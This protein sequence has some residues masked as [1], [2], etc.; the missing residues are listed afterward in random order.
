MKNPRERLQKV[1]V[2]GATPAGIAA[3]NKLGEMG[4][5]VTLIDSAPDLNEKLASDTWR[6]PSGVTF[7]Y[8][9]RPGLLRIMRNPRIRLLLPASVGSIKHTPQGFSIR[10]TKAAVYV[11]ADKCTLC[12]LCEKNCPAIRPDGTRA[13]RY[14]GRYELPG[15]PVI[16]KRKTPLCQANCPLGVNV[17]GYIALAQAG[18]YAEAIELIRKDNFLPAICGRICTNPCEA[19]C[20]RNEVDQPVAIRDIKR[21]LADLDLGSHKRPLPEIKAR[22]EQKVAIIGSGP[23]GLSC[24]Y[25]LA[26][27]G[28]KVSVFEKLPV[29]GGMLSVGIPAYRL[30]KDVIN[31]E[32][33]VMRDMGVEFQTGVEAGRDFT[34]S[35]L[36]AQGFKAFFMGP[37]LQK[38][39][40]LGIPGEDLEGVV[41]GVEYLRDI[42]LGAQIPLGNRVAIIGGGSVA[43]DAAR[44]VLRNGSQRPVIIYRRSE[45]EMPAIREEV[46]ECREEGIE[47]M[48]LTNPSRIVGGNGR[49][50]GVECIKM[51]LGEPDAGGRRRP[52]PIAGSEFVMEV[53]AVI[54]AIGQETDWGP[55]TEEC[56]FQ[57]TDHGTI[58]VNQPTRNSDIFVGGDAVTGPSTVVSAMASGRSTAFAIHR[59][60]SGEISDRSSHSRP[61]LDFPRI[62]PETPCVPRVVKEHSPDSC[63]GLS[64][65]VDHGL[66]EDQVLSEASRCLQC[67]VCS[68]C[69]QCAEVCPAAGAISHI[70]DSTEGIEHAGVVIIADPEAAPGIKGEDVIRAY[71]AK[72]LNPEVFSMMSRGFSAAAEAILL[73][74]DSAPR[75]KGR[76]L[77]FSPPAPQLSSE[78]R[79]GVFVCRCNDSLG[80][81]PELERFIYDLPEIPGVE[82]AESIASACT[83]EGSASILRTIR[84]KGLT[85]FVLASCVC[86]PLDL[87][88]SACTD[89]RSRLKTALFQGTGITRAMAET[90]NLR[91][92]ALSLLGRDPALAVSRF[93]GL[94]QRSISRC[95][96]LKSFPTPARQYN[97]TTAVIGDSRAALRS[98]QTLGEMGME[99]FLFGSS[100]R[101]LPSTPDCPNVHAFYGSCAKSLRGTVGEFELV[102]S[103][104]DGGRQTFS[105]GA[106][107]LGDSARK[108]LAYM[109]H[110]DMPPHEFC[111]SM[112]T[113]GVSGI[114]FSVPGATSIPG[115]LLANPP[116]VNLSERIKGSAAAILAAS[117]MPRGPRQSKGYTVS[118]NDALCRG[119][120]RC[121]RACPYRAI[122]FHTNSS[123]FGYAVIDEALCKGC[124]N[125]ISICPSDAADSPYRD[126]F[127]LEQIIEEVVARGA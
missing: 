87:I 93:K 123:G 28:Y 104:E 3:T 92:E 67:G 105:V 20:R 42:N 74:G 30:P 49:V 29:L 97:F 24:A 71:S 31:A 100:E 102:V 117:V 39:K 121:V 5:Q 43:V 75:M 77:S 72:T 94:L 40:A 51:E 58:Q 62:R 36:R 110:P 46:I 60:L 26:I 80:W 69:R 61:E 70:D 81:D 76:G 112:Q 79:I 25:H 86:C 120:G 96:H 21:F 119:C 99:V 103:M 35:Q 73:L 52:I 98:A 101:P 118:I 50:Q 115:L 83:P 54:P 4:I 45:N 59:F 114:P 122:S 14:G 113:N 11:D 18:K 56:G 65:E 27:E 111:Y 106:I 109:P 57:S 12:G 48:P 37:G 95:A 107:I 116:G 55:L 33:Q 124:G 84:E 90:C 82:Y 34:I 16:D 108:N 78:L 127:L 19:A 17:Q 88:C 22:R 53:D 23:A 32:I 63:N 126:N 125:C 10:Y 6:M 66:T 64:V 7:N 91:G 15:R 13:L 41:P 38:C 89:Q 9:Q 2:I 85:R 47:I 8:A 68:D 1:C 44:T